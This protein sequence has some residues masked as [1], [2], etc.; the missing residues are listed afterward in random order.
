MITTLNVFIQKK[1]YYAAISSTMY[2]ILNEFS[3]TVLL[4]KLVA[5]R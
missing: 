1:T 3:Q 5:E 2:K 4:L